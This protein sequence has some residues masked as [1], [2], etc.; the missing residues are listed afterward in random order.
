MSFQ[1]FRVS[2]DLAP[3]RFL[4]VLYSGDARV[5]RLKQCLGA[6]EERSIANGGNN[7]V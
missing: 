6:S 3:L 5:V 4:L 2:V 1:S 7:S